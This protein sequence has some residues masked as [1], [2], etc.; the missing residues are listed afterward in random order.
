MQDARRHRRAH[1]GIRNRQLDSSH[2]KLDTRHSLAAL[3]RLNKVYNKR[4]TESKLR[5]LGHP[6][7]LHSIMVQRPEI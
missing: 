5:A 7:N 6:D 3:L 2:S 4:V 1:S